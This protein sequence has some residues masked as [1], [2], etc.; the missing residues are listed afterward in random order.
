MWGM[1]S[2]LSD[3]T[4]SALRRYFARAAGPRRQAR[5]SR[6]S[7]QQGKH[8]FEE[9]DPR[10]ADPSLRHLPRPQCARHEHISASCGSACA[11]LAQATA[12]D[13]KRAAHGAGDARSSQGL[14]QAANGSRRRVSG[15]HLI[16]D[17]SR[18]TSNQ[19]RVFTMQSNITRRAVV[20]SGLMATAAVSALG[21]DRQYPV[22]GGGSAPLDPKDPT[23][24]KPGVRQRCVQGRCRRKS[25]VYGRPNMCQLPA[26]SGQTGRS[27]G[28]CVLFAGKSV[29]AAGWCKVWR[30]TA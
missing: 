12:G 7:S 10:P 28:G 8:L 6:R 3:P 23:A 16:R 5:E 14:D 4:I 30:K 9:G 19:Q 11:V 22:S 18:A 24:R 27:R 21:L 15:V 20:K 29:P 2:Q 17:G 1:A 13:S 26:V 25:Q